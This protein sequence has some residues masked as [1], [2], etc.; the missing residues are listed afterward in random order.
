LKQNSRPIWT[1]CFCLQFV[2]AILAILLGH[3]QLRYV[4]AEFRTVSHKLNC[5]GSGVQ[6]CLA[7]FSFAL[8]R[9]KPE[10]VCALFT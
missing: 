9:I 10:K 8:Q 6:V 4:D 3:L 7:G 5:I 1:G 2:A